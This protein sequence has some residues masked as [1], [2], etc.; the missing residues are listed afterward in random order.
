MRRVPKLLRTG[1]T[2]A[3]MAATW[4]HA[5]VAQA[6]QT[7]WAFTSAACSGEALTRDE[8]PLLVQGLSIRWFNADCQVVSSY[9]VKDTLFLQA[10]CISEGKSAT[11]PVMLEPRDQTLRVGWNREPVRE[12]QLCRWTLELGYH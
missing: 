12:M 9:R 3:V 8:T 4:A 6:V 10:Q 11:I 1:L 5:A 2:A 7:R